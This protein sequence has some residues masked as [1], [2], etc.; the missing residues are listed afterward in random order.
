MSCQ[1]WNC[2][3]FTVGVVS[4]SGSRI[5]SRGQSG[6]GEP[7]ARAYRQAK[8]PLRMERPPRRLSNPDNHSFHCE[9]KYQGMKA[10]RCQFRQKLLVLPATAV[11]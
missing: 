10:H 8:V 2:D 11:E 3:V 5:S 9:K 7:I 6:T 4:F 1:R